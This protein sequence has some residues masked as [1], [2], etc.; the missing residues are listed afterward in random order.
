VGED[1]PT[2]HGV[3][4]LTYMATIP[5]MIVTAPRNG[6]ELRDLL[7]TA[8]AQN[9]NPFAIR[10]PKD[11]CVEFDQ[12]REPAILKIG[13]WL[14]IVEGRDIAV[15]SVGIMTNLAEKALKLVRKEGINPSLIHAQFTKPFDE[16]YLKQTAKCHR[17]IITIEENALKGGFGSTLS[18]IVS[19]NGWKTPVISLGLPDYF[20]EHGAREILLKNLGLDP[21]GIAQAIREVA[22]SF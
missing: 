2:H 20:I 22:H 17:Y 5:N 7:F 11:T 3:F 21:A 1:G 18:A 16:D 12:K 10:Y 6:N 13:Q 8:L 15:I 19:K 9:Q 4:D 14:P